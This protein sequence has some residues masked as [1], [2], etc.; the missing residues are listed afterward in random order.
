MAPYTARPHYSVLSKQVRFAARPAEA[1]SATRFEAP[2]LCNHAVKGATLSSSKQQALP[3]RCRRSGRKRLWLNVPGEIR[4]MVCAVI[5]L[6]DK[7]WGGESVSQSP[8][9]NNAFSLSWGENQPIQLRHNAP[10]ARDVAT[11]SSRG[12]EGSAPQVSS[13]A[14]F[15]AA[16]AFVRSVVFCTPSGYVEG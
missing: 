4:S 16:V 11:A 15:S 12:L 14:T 10:L 5:S 3:Q 8:L 7:Q 2:V 13:C 6:M 1:V 9:K